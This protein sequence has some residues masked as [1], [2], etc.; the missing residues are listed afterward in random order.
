MKYINKLLCLFFSV[1]LITG[2]SITPPKDK[3]LVSIDS[4]ASP[5]PI[6]GLDGKIAY[7]LIPGDE[8]IT[9][10]DPQFLEFS[11]YVKRALDKRGYYESDSPDVV[12][13]FSYEI[14]GP[15]QRTGYGG[16]PYETYSRFLVIAAFSPATFESD[17]VKTLWT[18]TVM[19]TGSGGDL[20]KL[21]PIML[22]A[23]LPYLTET[24]T[25]IITLEVDEE[26]E[27]VQALKDHIFSEQI[28]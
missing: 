19:S 10:D 21:L 16:R 25:T 26:S 17:D 14:E 12:I 15:T 8:E 3:Y 2:C 20:S 7:R 27:S 22:G 6:H 9:P 4:T 11:D 28:P 13:G 24:T 5:D 23:A 18:T 1:A